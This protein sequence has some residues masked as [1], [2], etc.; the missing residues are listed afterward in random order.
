MKTT[1][2]ILLVSFSLMF[3]ALSVNAAD[4]CVIVYFFEKNCPTCEKIND[5]VLPTIK[6]KYDSRIKIVKRDVSEIENFEAMMAFEAEYGITPH[7]VPEFYTSGGVVW[8]PDNVVSELPRLIE[9]A[10]ASNSDAKHSVFFSNYLQTGKT[11]ISIINTV[12]KQYKSEKRKLLIYEF[13]KT[14][15]GACDRVGITMRYLMKKYPERLEVMSYLISDAD[16]ALLNEAFC[17][18]YKVPANR[19]LVTPALFFGRHAYNGAVDLKD[20]DV[21]KLVESALNELDEYPTEVPTDSDLKAAKGVITKRYA[22]ISWTAV[23]IAGLLDGVNPC[24]FITIIFLLSY[25]SMMKYGK[26]QI[27]MVG[28]SFTL[29]VFLTYLLIGLGVLKFLSIVQDT[30]YIAGIIYYSAV[31]MAAVVGLLNLIDYIRIRK[32][33]VRDMGLKLHHGL[34]QRINAVIRNRVKLRHYVVG[35]FVMGVLVSVLELACTGQVYLPTVLFI[36]NTE[37]VEFKA[38]ILLTLYNL[39]FIVPLMVIFALFWHGSTEKRISEWLTNHAAKFKLAMGLLFL[40]LAVFLY[41]IKN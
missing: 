29:A 3:S 19:H 7:A 8:N 13:K 23:F 5:T 32:G 35:A 9:L 15:C 33:S 25:L 26:K 41:L 14:G 31:A 11:G 27:A 21:V 30:P 22:A 10:L 4:K 28:L 17:L 12:R 6:A 34:R 40:A 18:K 20:K 39:A 24:A 36:I 37:G 16:S 38:F 1:I 2:H